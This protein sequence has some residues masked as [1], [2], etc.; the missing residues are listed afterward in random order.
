MSTLQ[1]LSRADLSNRATRESLKRVYAAAF[2]PPP[3]NRTA[4]DASWFEG[5]LVKHKGYA[6]FRGFVVEDEGT[7]LGFVYGYASK[8]GH[9]WHDAVESALVG[10]PKAIW[11]ERAFEVVELAVDPAAQGRGFGGRLHDAL[12]QEVSHPD[13]SQ[14]S[15]VHPNPPYRRALL[16]TIDAETTAL[17]LYRK[18]GWTPLL[19]DFRFPG[20][21]VPTLVM[22]LE[23]KERPR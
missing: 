21:S 17:A 12:L 11:L 18:R 15:F 2:A 13:V 16:S 8:R 9:W 5:Q 3:Y 14:F 4:R 6:G 22:G 7:V 19:H 1:S 10:S 20:S 23:F